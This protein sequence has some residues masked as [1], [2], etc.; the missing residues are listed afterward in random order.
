M[1]TL[2]TSRR[3]WHVRKAARV[4]PAEVAWRP[5][6]QA[7]QLAWSPR[8]VI[9][10]QVDTTLPQ[11]RERRSTCGLSA[12]DRRA[13]RLHLLAQSFD[14]ADRID[15]GGYGVRLSFCLGLV[16]RVEL[17][18]T[19]ALHGA[20]PAAPRLGPRGWHRGGPRWFRA[21]TKL[22]LGWYSDSLDR[23]VCRFTLARCGRPH[24]N[25]AIGT[26]LEFSRTVRE[27]NHTFNQ[28]TVSQCASGAHLAETPRSEPEAA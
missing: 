26:W 9:R 7:L 5:R 23:H 19:C 8:Q 1:S 25:E 13:A 18:G 6:D 20:G 14:T 24:P 15:S 17:N 11:A 27:A 21:Q 22:I 4:S 28:F 10:E 3:V 2:G 16:V 12:G